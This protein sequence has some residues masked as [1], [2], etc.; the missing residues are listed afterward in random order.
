MLPDSILNAPLAARLAAT[1]LSAAQRFKKIDRCLKDSTY[2]P[3]AREKCCH[4]HLQMFATDSSLFL[5][6][7]SC[8]R[9]RLGDFKF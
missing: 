3:K 6:W 5:H 1:I 8:N 2:A 4:K 7:L 9:E